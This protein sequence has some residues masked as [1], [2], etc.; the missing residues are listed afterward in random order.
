MLKYIIFDLD[1]T[2]YPRGNELM[3]EIGRRI[4]TWLCDYLELTWEEASA[5]RRDYFIRYGTTM[6]GL[7]AE[8][9]VDVRDY[10]AF[11]HDIPAE[12]YL[13]PHPALG[14]M[15]VP[16]PLRK[17]VF[18]NAI[19]EHGWRVL[20]ALGVAGHFE[21]VIGIEEVGLRNKLH[22]DA[23]ERMLALLGARGAECIMVED[24][25]RN[26]R[27]A[28]ALG[29]TTVLVDAEADE[30]VDFAVGSVLE[31]VEVVKGLIECNPQKNRATPD[32][33]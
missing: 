15:L 7:I 8:H 28:K 13:A 24:A 27:P 29:M 6:G 10:L 20:R 5:V 30:C 23:Y 4:Q 3:Q 33:R 26:L 9:G 18:T 11:V 19:A 31:V 1:E 12:E 22:R 16:I 17:V 25:A 32:C 14:A 21:R 2:L